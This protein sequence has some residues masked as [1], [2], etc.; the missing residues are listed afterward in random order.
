ML[1]REVSEY[2][3]MIQGEFCVCVCVQC[4]VVWSAV[5]PKVER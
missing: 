1:S 4:F 3:C 2:E 5:L